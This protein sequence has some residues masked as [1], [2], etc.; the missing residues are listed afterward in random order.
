MTQN[1]DHIMLCYYDKVTG[2]PVSLYIA[3]SVSH[4]KSHIM[5]FRCIIFDTEIITREQAKRIVMIVPYLF[6]L[7]N[8]H[9]YEFILVFP[10]RNPFGLPSYVFCCKVS[11]LVSSYRDEQLIAHARQKL[12]LF[13]SYFYKI[14]IN[15]LPSALTVPEIVFCDS[16]SSAVMSLSNTMSTRVF[17][18]TA[19][20]V[21]SSL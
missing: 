4:D 1:R 10:R 3:I 12:V 6:S 17:K 20:V 16:C 13:R 21:L 9:F 5:S 11:A 2:I 15:L 18:C 7:L 19:F 14:G 8:I